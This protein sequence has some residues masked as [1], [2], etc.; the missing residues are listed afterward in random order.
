WDQQTLFSGP[1]VA[2]EPPSASFSLTWDLVF[3]LQ[4]QGVELL[5]LTHATGLSHT[6]DEAIDRRLPLPERYRLS[7][8]AQRRLRELSSE[9]RPIIAVG[10]GVVRALESWA[11]RM[12]SPDWAET[13]LRIEP[14]YPLR[15][16]SGLLTGLHDAHA[17]HM[18]MLQAF[19]PAPALERAYE[20][21]G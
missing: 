2:L 18:D 13:D 12:L 4:Q 14:Q 7:S 3:R 19:V 15:I 8:V 17:S 1:A 6:G 5:K 16:V 10:T 11:G 9:Q 21:A 20:Q